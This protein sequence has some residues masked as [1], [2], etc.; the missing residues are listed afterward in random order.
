MIMLMI[1]AC[2]AIVILS[3]IIGIGSIV[4]ELNYKIN[5]IATKIAISVIF[6]MFILVLIKFLMMVQQ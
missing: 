3:A 4:F 5:K 2:V 1:F 6:L